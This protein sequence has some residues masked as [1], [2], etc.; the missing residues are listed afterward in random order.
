[1]RKLHS[2]GSSYEQTLGYSRAVQVDDMLFVSATAAGGPDGKIVGDDLYSQ[3]RYILQK[4][5]GVLQEAGFALADVV[6][7][8][9]YVTDVAKWQEAGR[10]HGEVFGDIRPALTLL[11]VLP[12]V[13]PAMLVEV[14]ITARKSASA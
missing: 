6:Q 13:D 11:H 12:F 1:M 7:S 3:T 10:A 2:S 8:R 5:E 4:L 9:L 14:E